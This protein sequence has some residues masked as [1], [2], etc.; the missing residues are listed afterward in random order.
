M[1]RTAIIFSIII[2]L[3]IGLAWYFGFLDFIKIKGGS[4]AVNNVPSSGNF[5]Y[6]KCTNT[7]LSNREISP[8]NCINGC[9][10]NKIG[11]DCE[12]FLNANCSNNQTVI[13]VDNNQPVPIPLPNPNLSPICDKEL[14]DAQKQ[15][16]ASKKVCIELAVAMRCPKD[17]QIRTTNPCV[18]NILEGKGWTKVTK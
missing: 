11:Y 18:A 16:S 6:G 15:F 2:V 7:R 10:Q 14:S 4:C 13:I 12:G 5:V 9:D 3:L 17:N 8:I 1:N